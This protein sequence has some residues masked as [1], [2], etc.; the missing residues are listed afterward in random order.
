MAEEFGFYAKNVTAKVTIEPGKYGKIV[1]IPVSIGFKNQE[2]WANEFFDV[3]V[4]ESLQDQADGISKGDKIKVSGRVTLNEWTAKDGT[5]KKTWQILASK[6]EGP[7]EP[8]QP[9]F[10][11]DSAPLPDDDVP[12]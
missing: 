5:T 8:K 9:A 11:P 7:A 6:I 10:D 2:K 1:K 12:F 3:I 4:F